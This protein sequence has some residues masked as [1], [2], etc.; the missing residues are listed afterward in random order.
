LFNE[1]DQNTDGHI[2][3]EEL[4]AYLKKK[5]AGLSEDDMKLLFARFD[6]NKQGKINYTEFI[7]ELKPRG[8]LP[9]KEFAE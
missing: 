5:E 4:E 3:Y 6:Q 7:T 9:Q 1:I 8:E 2:D